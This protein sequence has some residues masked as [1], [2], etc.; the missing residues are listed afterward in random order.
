M[1]V[2]VKRILLAAAA[3]FCV[4]ALVA[5]CGPKEDEAEGTTAPAA[6]TAGTAA[7]PNAPPNRPRDPATQGPGER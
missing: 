3:A 6:G 5:G 4:T 2:Q 1:N 7:V